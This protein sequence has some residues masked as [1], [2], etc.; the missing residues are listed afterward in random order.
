VSFLGNWTAKVHDSQG[1]WLSADG[2][3]F[4]RDNID[5]PVGTNNQYSTNETIQVRPLTIFSFKPKIDV[6]GSYRN[7]ETVIVR[8]RIEFIDNVISD[9]VVRIFNNSSSIWL[10]DDDMMKLFPSQNIIWTFLVDAKSSLSSTDAVVTVSG[11][12]VAG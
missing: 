10:S 1:I 11:Y 3:L 6:H 4:K 9:P 12:G 7:N 8:V 2:T 5:V